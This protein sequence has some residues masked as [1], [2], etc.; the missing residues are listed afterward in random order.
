MKKFLLDLDIQFF[1]KTLAE[2]LINPQVLAD[3]VAGE[4]DKALRFT[5][6][7]T[8]D[9]TLVGTPGNT[10]TRPKY[11][12]IGAAEDLK[13]GVAMEP[14]AMSMTTTPVTV[15][16]TGKAIEVTQTAIITNVDGTIQEGA[17][18]IGLAIADKIEIDFV[19]SAYTS[20][21]SIAETATSPSNILKA[22][23][24]LNTEDDQ[25]LVLFINPKDYSKLLETL[26]AVGGQIQQT[27]L[28]SGQVAQLVG[29]ANIV[30]TK[31]VDE[32]KGFL[33]IVGAIEIVKK[34]EVEIATDTDILA[35]TI[36]LAGNTHYATNL[37]N[38]NGVVKF[39]IA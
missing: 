23:D 14:T 34:K 28:A 8:V 7:A 21:L 31:R 39:G 13:E 5:P 36:V 16:E 11:A 12:Y 32:G 20:L 15:K 19:A 1:A 3:T 10:I 17:R 29:V 4:L 27:A 25:N 24:V 35:R 18:Q 9:N 26:F 2:D 22:I 37:K 38:D 30:R 6:Y 33:Q